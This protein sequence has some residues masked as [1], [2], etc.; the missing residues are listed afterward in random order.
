[1]LITGGSLEIKNM[2]YVMQ[3]LPWLAGGLLHG[4]ALPPAC[5]TQALTLSCVSNHVELAAHSGGS[6]LDVL[7]HTLAGLGS[8]HLSG[9]GR[10]VNLQT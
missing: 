3:W 10:V 5:F 2:T 1:L 4:K 7:K 6:P 8:V 9:V